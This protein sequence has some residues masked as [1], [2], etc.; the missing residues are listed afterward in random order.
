[1][2]N[3]PTRVNYPLAMSQQQSQM[4]AQTATGE[5]ESNRAIQEVQ[6]ALVIAKKFPR[7]AMEAADR[8]V[9][10]C[11]RQGLAEKAIY[12]FPRGGQQ[13]E[14]PSIELAKTLAR[15]WGNINYG[16]RELSN[17]GAQST[18]E[19]FAWDLETNTK[20][21]KVFCVEHMRGT[22]QGKKPLPDRS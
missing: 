1:M 10:A 9:N 6:A 8:I 16:F 4:P 18:V 2:N 7:N 17:D 19:A 14:G 20:E 22:R 12:S 5:A 11:T 15:E 21:V 13:V 3:M